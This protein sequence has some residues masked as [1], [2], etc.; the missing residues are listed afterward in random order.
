MNR[1]KGLV[2]SGTYLPS[3][4]ISTKIILVPYSQEYAV[5]EREAFMILIDALYSDSTVVT[6]FLYRDSC[7]HLSTLKEY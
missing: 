4:K 1:A 5:L 7:L 3:C 6:R 2:K